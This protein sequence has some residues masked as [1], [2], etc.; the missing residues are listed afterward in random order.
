MCMDTTNLVNVVQTV[1]FCWLYN[2]NLYGYLIQNTNFFGE[3][4][5]NN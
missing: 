1:I 4:G 5:N 3:Y 2:F